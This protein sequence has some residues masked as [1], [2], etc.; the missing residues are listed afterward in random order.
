MIAGD[1]IHLIA[2]G[3]A[4]FARRGKY[5]HAGARD[6]L[7]EELCAI[8]IPR[9]S[10]LQEPEKH[11]AFQAQAALGTQGGNRA[12]VMASRNMQP[13]CVGFG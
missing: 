9:G 1:S 7:S 12:A 8:H 6:K 4:E 10:P 13:P 11:I 2:A 5:T 3:L